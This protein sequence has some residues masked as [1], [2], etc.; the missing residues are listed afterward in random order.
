MRDRQQLVDIGRLFEA[1]DTST[2]IDHGR[3]EEV[4][5]VAAFLLSPV[6]SYVNGAIVQV[7]GGMIEA[8]GTGTK[9]PA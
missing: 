8:P 2:V 9:S 5:P 3:P 4:G 1:S 7:D 6:E